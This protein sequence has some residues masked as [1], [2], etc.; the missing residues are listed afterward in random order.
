MKTSLLC[1]R[2]FWLE[3]LSA[4]GYLYVSNDNNDGVL[5]PSEHRCKTTLTV[6]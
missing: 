4:I 3:S 1:R 5:L 6:M 2:E